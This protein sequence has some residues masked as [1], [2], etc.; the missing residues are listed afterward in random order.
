MGTA[1]VGSNEGAHSSAIALV[2]CPQL[3]TGYPPAGAG[4][5]GTITRPVTATILLRTDSDVYMT[6]YV[7]PSSPA[8]VTFCAF[9]SV[10]GVV[11]SGS[12]TE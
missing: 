5:R 9:I 4:V 8:A 11:G 10:P 6:R 3:T 12:G 2:P 1:W 7:V